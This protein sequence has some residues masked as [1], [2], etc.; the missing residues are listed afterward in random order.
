MPIKTVKLTLKWAENITP[1]VRHLAFSYDDP[2]IFQFTPGQFIT[3]FV[4]TAEKTLKR[5]YSIA[6]IAKQ[7]DLIEIAAGYVKDGPG[8]QLLF[9]LQPGDS[10]TAAG[11]FGRLVL[12]DEDQPKRFI[13][14]A[15]STGVTP[16]LSMLPQLS[17]RLA[18]QDIEAV[19]LQGVQKRQDLL[20]ADKFLQF[21]EQH[22]NFTFRAHFSREQLTDAKPHEFAGY[23]QSAFEDLSLNPEHDIVYLCGN[24]GMIDQS[25]DWLKEHGF[26]PQNVRREKYFSAK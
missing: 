8:T 17:E 12:R 4:E 21:A 1:N 16:Y 25:F 19:V 5:S 15:T 20:Y 7:S 10:V 6:T 26:A 23:V 11:P 24:P 3:I 22:D 9:G 18:K 2:A 14:V 13:F